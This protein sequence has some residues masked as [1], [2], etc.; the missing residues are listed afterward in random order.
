MRSFEPYLTPDKAASLIFDADGSYVPP[1]AP[2]NLTMDV[3][4][5]GGLP[6]YLTGHTYLGGEATSGVRVV[7]VT[8]TRPGGN[9]QWLGQTV[10]DENGHYILTI[11]STEPVWLIAHLP[12]STNDKPLVLGPLYAAAEE[13]AP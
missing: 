1:T 9:R 3:E 4:G 7:A 10:S 11:T 8:A 2:L 6:L 13:L 12:E 5:W